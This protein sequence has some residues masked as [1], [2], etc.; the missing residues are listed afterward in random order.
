MGVGLYGS[1]VTYTLYAPLVFGATFIAMLYYYKKNKTNIKSVILQVLC[2][3]IIPGLA[4]CYFM[5]IFSKP[6]I[7]GYSLNI[8]GYIYKD[9]YLNLIFFLP[10]VFIALFKLKEKKD[11]SILFWYII[12]TFAM[13]AI[14]LT[15][16]V[17]NIFSGYYFSKMYYFISL[18]LHMLLI[19]YLDE[20]FEKNNEFMFAYFGVYFFLMFI[21]I[22]DAEWRINEASKDMNSRF[23]TGQIFSL[24]DINMS[25]LSTTKKQMNEKIDFF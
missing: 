5:G 16:G 23:V 12:A 18:L 14:M 13:T 20:A 8:E 25:C 9:L 24:M 22:S 4:G 11:S 2:M 17:Y 15:G 10:F 19:L 3:Y 21:H 7:A 6:D 1:M